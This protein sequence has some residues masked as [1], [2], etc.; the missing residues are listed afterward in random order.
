MHRDWRAN[1]PALKRQVEQTSWEKGKSSR[2]Q[3]R[4]EE[5]YICSSRVNRHRMPSIIHTPLKCARSR[6]T[7]T[8]S[9]RRVLACEPVVLRLHRSPSASINNFY[10]G[11]LTVGP[12]DGDSD[13]DN[14]RRL[15]VL[16]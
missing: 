12:T 5:I 10:R 3:R 14:W 4:R 15:N 2:R 6:P 9:A 8:L 11:S 7:A 1:T 13:F 16:A